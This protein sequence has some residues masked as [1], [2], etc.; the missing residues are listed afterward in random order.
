MVSSG[1][2]D[3]V[4]GIVQ[5][6]YGDLTLAGPVPVDFFDYS[7]LGP[8]QAEPQPNDLEPERSLFLLLLIDFK[9]RKHLSHKF[10]NHLIVIHPCRGS[11]NTFRIAGSFRSDNVAATSPGLLAVYTT[12]STRILLPLFPNTDRPR[13]LFLRRSRLRHSNRISS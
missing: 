6:L 8:S 7:A 2:P 9:F 11:L 10:V 4:D 3:A 12:S 5:L 1:T 13:L